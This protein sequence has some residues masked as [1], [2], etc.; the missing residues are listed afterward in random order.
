MEDRYDFLY[1]TRGAVAAGLNAERVF[2][3]TGEDISRRTMV[4]S[5]NVW[6]T[7]ETD[8]SKAFRGFSILIH[9]LNV[10]EH[11]GVCKDVEFHC[12]SGF[13]ISSESVCDGYLDC[14]NYKDEANCSEIFCPGSY[15]C[16]DLSVLN[17]TTTAHPTTLVYHEPMTVSASWHTLWTTALPSSSLSYGNIQAQCIPTALVCNGEQDCPNLDDETECDRKRCPAGCD[18]SYSV[19]GEFVVSCANGWDATTLSNIA[20]TTYTLHL[21]GVNISLEGGIFKELSNLKVLSLKNNEIKEIPQR[22]FDGLDSLVWL[23]LSNTSLTELKESAMEELSNLRGITIFDVPLRKIESNAFA[24]LGN[25]ETLILVRNKAELSPLVVED[26][27]FG[28][29]QK[30][31]VLYVDNHQ[32][33]CFFP[34][35]VECKTLEPEPPL[36]MCSELMPNLVLKIFMWILGV[37]ALVGNIFVMI[38]RCREKTQ[39]KESR[40]VHSFFVFNLAVSDS[41]MGSYMLIIAGADLYFGSRYFEMSDEWRASIPCRVA[42]MISIVASEASVFFLTLISIDRFLAIVFPF[43]SHHIRPKGAKVIA[44]CIWAA[45]TVVALVPTVLS[46][47]AQSDVYG[48]SDVCIGLPLRTKVTQYETRQQTIE[49]Q[50]I[51]DIT[52]GIPVAVAT[53]ASWFFSIALFLGVNLLCFCLIL[54]CYIAIF[55][56]VI[57]SVRRVRRHKSRD[58]EIRM[59]LKMAAIVSTDFVCWMPVIMMGILAQ[60]RVVVI[61]TEAYAWIVVFILPINSSLNPYLYTISDL[62]SQRRRETASKERKASRINS[63]TGN[64]IILSEAHS[65]SI[66]HL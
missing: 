65:A 51:S 44:V 37:S 9:Q 5:E 7:L 47:D 59:A 50:G 16:D 23:D 56:N 27:A 53:H 61:P 62:C 41:L 2:A 21:S 25:V 64:S 15:K 26:S 45:T 13:C 19:E 52:V 33:C 32:I 66:K 39:G 49:V 55:V 48:L 1:V 60:A 22:T 36:F 46:S 29:L 38:W 12:G 42:G 43:S 30:V 8:D 34:D 54:A 40:M 4:W 3:L 24:G 31:S 35:S 11:S 57:R 14:L 28:G 20:A 10:S 6:L 58:D 18:C 17:T 63:E